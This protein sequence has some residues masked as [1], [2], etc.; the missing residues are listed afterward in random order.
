MAQLNERA[1]Q[2]K[3]S[4]RIGIDSGRVVV[5][6]GAGKA[7]DAFGD[8]ANIAARVEAAADADTVRISE[9]TYR[10]V[11]GM[12]VVEDRGPHELKGIEQPLQLYRVIRPSG[13]RG[14][15]EAI[16]AARGLT[17]FVG[18]RRRIA[19]ADESVGAR[20]RGGRKS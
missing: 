1:A 15:L 12:F 4:V 13:V 8:T 2:P 6:A 16:A 3:L 7:V 11:S 17:P 18:P 14:R 20:A 9:G 10:P 5:G 19:F